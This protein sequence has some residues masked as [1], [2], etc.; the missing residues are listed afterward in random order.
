MK[1]VPYKDKKTGK[2][3]YKF[4]VYIGT[5]PLT[6]KPIR[7]NRQGFE[8]KKQAEI[9]YLQLKSQKESMDKPKQYTFEQVYKMWLEHY[10]TTVKSSTLGK[11]KELFKNHILPELG[12]L[13]IDKINLKI[14]QNAVNNWNKKIK[15]YKD[16]KIY[17]QQVFKHAMRLE[18]V[19]KDP[20]ALVV[21]PKPKKSEIKLVDA[22]ENFYTKEELSVFL[23]LCKEQL[24]A[25]WYTLLHTLAYTG[26]RRGEILALTWKDIDFKTSRIRINKTLT[27]DE[28]NKIIVN[29]TKTTAGERNIK[30]DTQTIQL[31]KAWKKSK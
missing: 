15:K 13:F 25:M 1:I 7:T 10:Q 6:G 29:D 16:L 14:A 2:T 5:D 12:T 26:M 17:T 19:G 27:L 23:N 30:I 9:A 24:P 22:S 20:F 3:L 28:N 11:V 8:T 21:M 18:L 4:Y 31:L